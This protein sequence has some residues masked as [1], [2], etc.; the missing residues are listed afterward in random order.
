MKLKPLQQWICDACGEVIESPEQGWIEWLTDTTEL[1]SKNQFYHHGFKIV[2]HAAYSP[3][4]P[5]GTCYHYDHTP[6]HELKADTYL[7]EFLGYSGIINLL[8]LIEAGPYREKHYKGPHIKDFR[9]WTELVRRLTIPHYEEARFYMKR[10]DSD[11]FF[12]GA[13]E[14]WIYLPKTLR[15][16]IKRYGD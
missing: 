10:A 14:I 1:N 2:H 7:T 11:G 15:Q 8:F 6:P 13:S 3:R 5:H 9:E 12:E 4:K 16:V